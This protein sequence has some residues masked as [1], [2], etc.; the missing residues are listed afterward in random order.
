MNGIVFQ[1]VGPPSAPPITMNGRWMEDSKDFGVDEHLINQINSFSIS[2]P[3]LFDDPNTKLERMN[4][5]NDRHSSQFPI[6]NINVHSI[7][8]IHIFFL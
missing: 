2:E 7:H 4:Q 6:L 8:E 3:K 1:E 5:S